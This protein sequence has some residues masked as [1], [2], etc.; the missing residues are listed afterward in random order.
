MCVYVVLTRFYAFARNI[1]ISSM[2]NRYHCAVIYY[3]AKV[4]G[5]IG[6]QQSV[7]SGR[8]GLVSCV[9]HCSAIYV[10]VHTS[11]LYYD[12][13]WKLLLYYTNLSHSV[14]ICISY[15]LY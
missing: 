5:I 8:A 14:P 11:S 12:D 10:F 9:Y 3:T 6:R 15:M 4:K 13:L 7:T 1:W 2:M